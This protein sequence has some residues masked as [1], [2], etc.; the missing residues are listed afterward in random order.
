MPTSTFCASTRPSPSVHCHLLPASA[1]PVIPLTPC[2]SRRTPELDVFVRGLCCCLG[3]WPAH[4]QRRIRPGEAQCCGEHLGDTAMTVPGAAVRAVGTVHGWA[5][6]CIYSPWGHGRSCVRSPGEGL[7]DTATP[8][9][10]A[11]RRFFGRGA[12]VTEVAFTPNSGWCLWPCLGFPASTRACSWSLRSCLPA[13][14]PSGTTGARHHV[15]S[16][17]A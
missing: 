6:N 10:S 2:S 14:V 7:G 8:C 13:P 11:C 5:R 16:V 1:S 9:G 3:E 17:H 15:C 12:E 4:S